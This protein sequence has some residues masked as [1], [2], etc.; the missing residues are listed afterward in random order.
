MQETALSIIHIPLNS[1]QIYLPAILQLLF[2]SADSHCA[3]VR[4]HVPRYANGDEPWANRHSFLNVSVNLLEASIVCDR[5]LAIS[6]FLPVHNRAAKAVDRDSGDYGSVSTDDYVAISVEGA[7][8]EAGQRVLEVTSPLAVARVG[9][10]FITTYYSDYILVPATAKCQVVQALE[11]RGFTFEKGSKSYVNPSSHHRHGS[12]GSGSTSPPSSPLTTMN[13]LQNR[14]FSLLQKH[15]IVPRLDNR[16]RLVQCAARSENPESFVADDLAFQH[17]LT[18]CLIHQPQFLSVTMTKNQSAS[19]LI[20]KRLIPNF[21]MTG[22][23]ENVL[24]GAKEDIL[25]PITLDLSVLDIQASGIICGV[26]SKLVDGP[27]V[28]QPVDMSYLSTARAGWLMVNEH[29]TDDAMHYLQLGMENI[30]S[31]QRD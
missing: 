26:A 23:C 14:T 30:R 8:M 24:L 29:D 6:L 9:V 17:G 16:I 10:L 25:I 4:D 18:K 28:L 13:Q 1:Y 21:D 3:K 11:D 31:S 12:S 22:D 20:E 2:P 5:S 7:G 19:L 27:G 15:E